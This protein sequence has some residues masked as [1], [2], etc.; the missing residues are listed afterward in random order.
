MQITTQCLFLVVAIIGCCLPHALACY[1]P[2]DNPCNVDPSTNTC[3]RITHQLKA[4]DG[5]LLGS[6]EDGTADTAT[7]VLDSNCVCTILDQNGE[8]VADQR[9]VTRCG[10]G[11]VIQA[12]GLFYWWDGMTVET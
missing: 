7:S 4:H 10:G 8:A 1:T 5:S 9:F 2:W 3:F 6:Y 12:T 11:T